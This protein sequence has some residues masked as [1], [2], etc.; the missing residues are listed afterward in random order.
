MGIGIELCVDDDEVGT[1]VAVGVDANADE[2][3]P[4]PEP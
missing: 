3:G 2:E 1:V 4:A